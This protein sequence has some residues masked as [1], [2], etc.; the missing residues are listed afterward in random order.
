MNYAKK[1]IK[2]LVQINGSRNHFAK[3]TTISINTIKKILDNERITPSLDTLI[4]IHN[5]LG[6]SL[7]DL[8]FKDLEEINNNNKENN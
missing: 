8:V 3:I 6:I 5:T 2:Y 7:D 4:K 1:N